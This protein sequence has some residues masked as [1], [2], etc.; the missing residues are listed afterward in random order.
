MQISVSIIIFY[1]CKIRTWILR[2]VPISSQVFLCV[3]VS[4]TSARSTM[5]CLTDYYGNFPANHDNIKYDLYHLENDELLSDI[6]VANGDGNN[7]V[8]SASDILC[9]TCFQSFRNMLAYNEHVQSQ[10]VDDEFYYCKFCTVRHTHANGLTRHMNTHFFK[11]TN[12]V[13]QLTPLRHKC[14]MCEKS[15]KTSAKLGI[16]YRTHTGEK[17]FPCPYCAYRSTQSNNL[18]T[19][20][21]SKHPSTLIENA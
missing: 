18:K 13:D 5:S 8:G 20:I 6:K 21:L 19:H 7:D 14:T 3:Q 15:F 9:F 1:V 17:P 11:Q 4:A 2:R 16:H 12:V 10:H